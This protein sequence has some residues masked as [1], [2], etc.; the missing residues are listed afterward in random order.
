MMI[1]IVSGLLLLLVTPLAA[2][3]ADGNTAAPRQPTNAETAAEGG[4]VDAFL[5]LCLNR[6]PDDAAFAKGAAARQLQPMAPAAVKQY[7]HDD[8]GRGWTGQSP[9]GPYAVT[10]ES[11]PY[12]ACGVRRMQKTSAQFPFFFHLTI[13]T[14]A[15]THAIPPRQTVPPMRQANNGATITITAE[16]VVGADGKP[17]QTFMALVTD[18][19]SGQ[20]EL[21]LVRQFPPK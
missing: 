5:D 16:A 17:T 21:R 20:S 4:L 13:G 9:S 6:F 8:P 2:H 14:W 7:L 10:I 18:Y 3:A 11:P 15:A 19:P 12:L 1:R